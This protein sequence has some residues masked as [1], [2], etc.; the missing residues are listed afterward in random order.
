MILKKDQKVQYANRLHVVVGPSPESGLP[1]S[2]NTMWYNLRTTDGYIVKAHRNDIKLPQA[3]HSTQEQ[4][5]ELRNL[6]IEEGYDV[7]SLDASEAMN[8]VQLAN[9]NGLYDAAD[10][11]RTKMDRFDK[12]A[13]E[14]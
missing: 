14:W 9:T 13:I 5:E 3:Q 6:A 4:V 10:F 7:D 12:I 2:E 11:I 8:I 1:A